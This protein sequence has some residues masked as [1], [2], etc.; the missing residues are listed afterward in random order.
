MS[1]FSKNP[2]LYI[3]YIIDPD[4]WQASSSSTTAKLSLERMKFE[5]TTYPKKQ[6]EVRSKSWY[7]DIPFYLKGIVPRRMELHSELFPRFD[8]ID[9]FPLLIFRAYR[10]KGLLSVSN[11]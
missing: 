5:D 10:C 1:F 6:L 8:Y 2:K 11:L 3:D 7:V 9:I 4:D